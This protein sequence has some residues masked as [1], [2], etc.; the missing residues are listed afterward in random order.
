MNLD[1]VVG[2]ATSTGGPSIRVEA[3]AS[4]FQ[5]GPGQVGDRLQPRASHE[6]YF[7]VVGADSR[8][9]QSGL[10]YKFG[11]SWRGCLIGCHVGNRFPPNL[12]KPLFSAC[13]KHD[14]V[15]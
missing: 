7:A 13:F 11:K 6:A 8:S 10:V 9:G 2:E 15:H 14:P 12:G 4:E 5:F 1:L 3:N